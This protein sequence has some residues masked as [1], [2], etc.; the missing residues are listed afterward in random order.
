MFLL[1]RSIRPGPRAARLRL[2]LPACVVLAG[3]TACDGA[4]PPPT[5]A[6]PAL[7]GPSAA[8]GP[9]TVA[10]A[11]APAPVVAVVEVPA[12]ARPSVPLTDTDGR[13]RSL[14]DY[15]GRVVALFFGFT[16]C[17]DICGS[18][19]YR[20]KQA[21]QLLGERRAQT[22]FVM[23]SVDGAH[24]TPEVMA[25][26]VKRFDP[27]FIGLTGPPQRVRALAANFGG[28]ALP[29]TR[30]QDIERHGAWIHTAPVYLIDRD[31]TWRRTLAPSARAEDMAA[32]IDGLLGS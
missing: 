15:Q 31:G 30:P 21:A 28:V 24:D 7:P 2:V 11:Q 13:E 1:I 9:Q 18:T 29:A 25:S 8:P 16:Q 17:P 14:E 32:A 12:S 6:P 22:A 4:G 5:P 10:G 3:L 20:L 26:Y 23:V 27:G 19:M